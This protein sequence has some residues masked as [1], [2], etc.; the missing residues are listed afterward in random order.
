VLVMTATPIPRTLALTL[1][2]DLDISTIDELPPG[3][4]PI[5]T[6]LVDPSRSAEVYQYVRKRLDSGEQAYIVVPLIDAGASSA[7][8]G[9]GEDLND[10]RTVMARLEKGES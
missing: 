6:R 4:T 5:A 3:R 8:E 1:L 10:L 9:G 2:G 7:G